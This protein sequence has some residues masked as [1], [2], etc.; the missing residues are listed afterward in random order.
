MLTYVDHLSAARCHVYNSH[1]RALTVTASLFQK[2]GTFTHIY[3]RR[4]PVWRAKARNIFISMEYM[5][6]HLNDRFAQELW[7][8]VW[9]VKKSQV[10]VRR[11][12]PD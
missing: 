6:N 1:D 7:V 4:R 9:S 12:S 2:R 8:Q 5:I 11:H 3:D 10:G